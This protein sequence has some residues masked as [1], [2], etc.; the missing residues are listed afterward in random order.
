[1]GLISAVLVCRK[2]A[3]PDGTPASLQFQAE[4]RGDARI[5]CRRGIA[6]DEAR[7]WRF[8]AP[9]LLTF[10]RDMAIR[11]DPMRPFAGARPH[12]HPPLSLEA[13][14]R[15]PPFLFRL[16]PPR[17]SP[18]ST[19]ARSPHRRCRLQ[20]QWAR[21]RRR[22][23]PPPPRG[24][25]PGNPGRA[26]LARHCVPERAATPDTY[27]P[28]R[29]LRANRGAGV[30]VRLPYCGNRSGHTLVPRPVFSSISAI[31]PPMR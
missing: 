13:A 6:L 1:V 8:G 7:P 14:F 12:G 24:H 3:R 29:E 5:F 25:A 9:S 19:P 18:A 27:N 23:P 17:V 28:R 15:R 10:S 21:F 4:P 16:I 2:P 11:V 20:G 22:D 31:V 30:V 26:S